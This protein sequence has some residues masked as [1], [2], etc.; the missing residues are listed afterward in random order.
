MY[1]N[2]YDVLKTWKKSESNKS[3]LIYGPRRIGKTFT[4]LE[5]GR[6]EYDNVAYF[7]FE[8]NKALANIFE[9]DLKA[10]R[11]IKELAIYKGVSIV[12]GKTLI[13]LD[14]IHACGRAL[15]FLRMLD[16]SSNQY[17]IMALGSILGILLSGNAGVFSPDNTKVICMRP[18]SFEEFLN[19]V[20]ESELIG[21]IGQYTENLKPMPEEI[22]TKAIELY[23]RY[24]VVGGYPEAIESYIKYENF[25]YVRSVQNSI[26]DSYISDMVNYSTTPNMTKAVEIYNSLPQQLLKENSKFMYSV[27]GTSARGKSYESAMRWLSSVGMVIKCNKVRNAQNPLYKYEDVVSFK[28]YAGDIGLMSM[29]LGEDADK[30]AHGINIPDRIKHVLAENFIAQELMARDISSYY[31]TSDNQ[32]ELDFV[33]NIGDKVIPIDIKFEDNEK[34]KSFGVYRSRYNP[35]YA[36]RI[37]MNNFQKDRK[38]ISIPIYAL[39]AF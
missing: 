37:S 27:I 21:T 39:F 29:M 28:L 6:N 16:E 23:Y 18:F 9:K 15:A 5:F 4:A 26:A 12:P 32:A 31:W 7:N 22:H 1:R 25:D 10:E 13:I 30:I 14:E 36:L 2:V 35:E 19:A 20:G 17:H 11:I 34:A 38:V 8:K 3:V 24:A 33:V